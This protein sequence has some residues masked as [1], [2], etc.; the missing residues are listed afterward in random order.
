MKHSKRFNENLEKVIREKEYSLDE[1]AE[2]LAGLSKTKFDESV[3]VAINLGVDPKHADQI[4][5]GTVALPNGTGKDVKV[6]VFA[7]GDMLKQAEEAGADFSGSDDMV[8]KV[9]GG[10]TDFDVVVAAPDMMGEVGKLGRILGPRGLMPNPKTGTVTTDISKAVS[11]VKAGKIEFRVDKT[12]IIHN[13]IGKVSFS[14]EKIVENAKVF[15]DA[16]LKAKPQAAKGTYMK[17]VTL[18]STMGPGIKLD[19]ASITG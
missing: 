4:V 16:I 5:R 10:W 7:K 13:I 8:E 11:E 9:K 2:I 15:V 19:K 1:A 12:G 14:K 3:E 18:T 17:K 6:L